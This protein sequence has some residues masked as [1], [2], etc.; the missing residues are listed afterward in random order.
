MTA[1]LVMVPGSSTKNLNFLLLNDFFEFVEIFPTCDNPV[2]CLQKLKKLPEMTFIYGQKLIVLFILQESAMRALK[3]SN[4]TYEAAV[5]YLKQQP[6]PV[7][8]CN[9]LGKSSGAG[10]FPLCISRNDI[11]VLF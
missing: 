9:G 10:E 2:K 11:S 3:Q 8:M 5:S 1:S 7:E 6:S 4:G